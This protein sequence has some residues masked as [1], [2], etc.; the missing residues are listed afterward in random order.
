MP[1]ARWTWDALAHPRVPIVLAGPAGGLAWCGQLETAATHPV[2]GKV[3]CVCAAAA[4]AR[5][6]LASG[7]GSGQQAAEAL[8]LLGRW[9]NEPNVERFDRICGLIFGEEPWPDFGP[10][11]VVWWALRTATSSV[12]NFEAGWALKSTCGAAECAGFGPEQ[13]RGV[14]EQE[15]VSRL[16][17]ARPA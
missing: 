12:G 1:D 9:I 15:L 3:L 17:R 11:G 14:V 10:H 2:V 4:V 5:E 13:L 8:E 6:V 7:L 16:G